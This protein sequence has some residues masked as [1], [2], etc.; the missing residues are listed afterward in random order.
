[1]IT[2]VAE[3]PLT[4]WEKLLARPDRELS[5]EDAS[6][7]LRLDFSPADHARMTELGEKVS[8]GILSPAE[9]QELDDFILVGH[10]LARLQALARRSL[11]RAARDE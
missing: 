3:R 7:L 10:Q 5:E 1:M 2:V 9:L 8:T 4:A 6:Y 11:R